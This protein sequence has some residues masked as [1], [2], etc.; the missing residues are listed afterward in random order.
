MQLN[1]LHVLRGDA[2]ILEDCFLNLKRESAAVFFFMSWKE[3]ER[4]FSAALLVMSKPM[5][6]MELPPK[7]FGESVAM[8]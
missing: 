5:S 2:S 4:P 7:A 6:S 8:C 3:R 1:H